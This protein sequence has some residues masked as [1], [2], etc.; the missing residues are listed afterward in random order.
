MRVS[1]PGSLNTFADKILYLA[2]LRFSSNS[3]IFV[4]LRVSHVFIRIA[5]TRHCQSREHKH[6]VN[7]SGR[8]QKS[9]DSTPLSLTVL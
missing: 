8:I 5:A 2:H 6:F 7:Q 4:A 3:S 9:C 1:K